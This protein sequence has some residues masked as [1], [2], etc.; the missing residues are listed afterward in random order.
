MAAFG[1]ALL[2]SAIVL[3]CALGAPLSPD[4][5]AA[6]ALGVAALGVAIA[7]GPRSS[8][9]FK[10]AL[11]VALLAGWS[12]AWIQRTNEPLV[13]QQPTAR[14][15]GTV[16]GDDRDEANGNASYTFAIDDGPTVTVN[17][18]GNAPTLG[19]RLLVRG[20]I[21]P[22][23][24]P[25]N[26][27]EPS[28]R[29]IER[30]RGIAARLAPAQVMATLPDRRGDWRQWLARAHGWALTQLRER[31]GEPQASIAAGELWGEKSALP[32]DARAEFQETGTVHILVTAG[33][34]LGVVVA[35]LIWLLEWLRTP[36]SAAAIAAIAC[37]WM[38]AFFAG[39]HVPVLRAATMLTVALIAR[40]CGRSALSW[41]AYAIAAGIIA[42]ARPLDVTGASFLLSFSCV[43]AILVCAEPL[44]AWISAHAELPAK[45]REAMSLA[46]ATQIGTWPV[47]AAVFLQFAP[48]AIA[49]NVLVVPIVGLS[50]LLGGAQLLLA[51][52]APL[53]QGCANLNGWCL[54]WMLGVV[55]TISSLPVARIPMTPAPAWCIA[56]YDVAVVSAVA[57][58]KRNRYRPCALVAIVAIALVLWP[59]RVGDHRL[60]ITA[61]DVGQ[62]DAIV[63][64]TPGGHTLLVDAGGQLERGAQTPGDSSAE[65]VGERIVVPFLLRHGIH[66]LDAIVLSHPHGDH[67]G[68]AAPVLRWLRVERFLDSGQRYGGA[69][70]HDALTTA[71]ANG[72]PILDG[73]AGDIW[74][75]DDGVTLTFIGP[76]LPFISG[77]TNDINDNSI[78]F[79]LQY[80]S[81]RM[82]F[83]GDAGTSAEQR[84]LAEGVDLHAD[85]LKVGHHGSAYGTT[86]AFLAAVR[87]RYAI[88]SVGRHNLFGHP[89]PS[90]VER[91]E[92]FGAHIYRTDHNGAIIV[93]TDGKDA[94]VTP[95]LP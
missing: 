17:E 6:V 10:I 55:Q 45:L 47:G 29:E 66:A 71:R 9:T 65:R 74:R 93:S 76:S 85:V 11:T 49:A 62:A 42:L 54:A 27:G 58:I 44:Q 89:A 30:E 31:L 5:R 92:R 14:Y 84:F 12:D 18:H 41:N 33:L 94:I 52:F 67:A 28:E 90:T 4:G 51:P 61:L 81:F 39:G 37:A 2:A 13:A 50:M 7:F 19:A 59:P 95:L 20:R 70:Y 3:G 88:I 82:L 75:T 22:F 40:A 79:V 15:A 60:R 53:A 21:E 35:L 46:I 23:D 69:A 72:V 38:Y 25:R 26:P 56:L 77:G 86:D 83:T 36:R 64:Q 8:A 78:A 63:V 1:I 73:R 48:Y 24:D 34:H 32:P 57:L 87:P 43:G 80:G 91:L 16:I 68:G